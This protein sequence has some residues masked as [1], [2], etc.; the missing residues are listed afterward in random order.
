MS[1]PVSP[2]PSHPSHRR[3]TGRCGW[4]TGADGRTPRQ[5]VRARH[6]GVDGRIARLPRNGAPAR[7]TGG[8]D[9]W[10]SSTTSCGSSP[11]I[12]PGPSP[13]SIPPPRAL[14]AHRSARR[15][16]AAVTGIAACV[17][18]LLVIGGFA[19]FAGSDDSPSVHTPAGSNGA[20]ATS[21]PT[22]GSSGCPTLDGADESAKDGP[23]STKG[24]DATRSAV[25]VGVQASDCVDDVDFSFDLGTPRWSVRQ[26]ASPFAD[27]GSG[28]TWYVIT[29]SGLAPTAFHDIGGEVQAHSP[30]G[31]TAV[32]QVPRTD[33]TIAWAI[34][35]AEERPFRVVVAEDLLRVQF[36]GCGTAHADVQQ[37]GPQPDAPLRLRRPGRVVRR[38]DQRRQHLRALLAATVRHVQRVRRAVRLGWDHGD[39]AGAGRVRA[40]RPRLV[41]RDHRRGTTARRCRRSRH[42]VKASSPPGTEPTSTSSTGLRRGR[43]RSGS[44]ACPGPT[45]TPARPVS[46]PSPP[47]S[48]ASTDDRAPRVG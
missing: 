33:G 14:R 34:G 44:A 7:A 3:S 37:L 11:L 42:R 31:V 40:R 47:A 16:A 26:E 9:Q 23:S 24:T 30:R 21:A 43:S 6:L 2:T 19:V 25:R 29:F 39:S 22:T 41:D 15:R 28:S 38:A 4:C 32:R 45:S 12:G 13:R 17:V 48:V 10:L 1:S 18:A 36:R 27:D 35:M 5:R 20:P 8:G 46:T